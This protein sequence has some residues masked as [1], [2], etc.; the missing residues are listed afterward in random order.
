MSIAKTLHTPEQLEAALN[1]VKEKGV[2][3]WAY[4]RDN[5]PK[6]VIGVDTKS[7]EPFQLFCYN[8][9]GLPLSVELREVVAKVLEA[10]HVKV[11]RG[12]DADGVSFLKLPASHF[13]DYF[14]SSAHGKEHS[15]LSGMG[16]VV[17]PEQD[18]EKITRILLGERQ[19]LSTTSESVVGRLGLF[20]HPSTPTAPVSEVKSNNAPKKAGP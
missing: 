4:E 14:S 17:R 5:Q 13:Y 8:T 20:S 19:K 7:R 11:E 18:V 15:I 3:F 9:R 2:F 1:T 10:Q 16:L 12:Q 6:I